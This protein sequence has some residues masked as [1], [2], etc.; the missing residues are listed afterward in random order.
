MCPAGQKIGSRARVQDSLL[1]F[2]VDDREHRAQDLVP[3]HDVPDRPVHG[4]GVQRVRQAQR[5]R[6]V[7]G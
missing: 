4:I 6:H 3:V 5:A 7:I 1:G 2:A